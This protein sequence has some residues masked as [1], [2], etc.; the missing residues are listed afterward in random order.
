M[1]ALLYGITFVL[2]CAVGTASANDPKTV[3]DRIQA[4][5]ERVAKLSSGKVADYA[6]DK[7]ASAQ[8]TLGAAKAAQ[9][10]PN[11]ALALQKVD[12][13]HIQLDQAEAAAAEKESAENLLLRRSELR[14]TEAQFDQYLQTGGK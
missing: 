6:K 7:I 13:A 10:V 4:L 11:V 1:K 8:A 5:S 2:A 12:L 14:K 9:A 3:A